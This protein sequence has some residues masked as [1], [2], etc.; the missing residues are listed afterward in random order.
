MEGIPAAYKYQQVK[1]YPFGSN[2]GSPLLLTADPWSYLYAWLGQHSPSKG[3]GKKRFERALYYAQQ[4]QGFYEASDATPLPTKATIVYYGMLNLVKAF[5]SIRGVELESMYEH[6]GLSLPH[7]RTKE[8]RVMPKTNSSLNIFH[9][10][11]N[12]LGTPVTGSK[13]ISL[14]SI[15][16][17]LP[18]IHEIT[19]S[20]NQLDTGKRKFLPI[21]IKFYVN[22]GKDKLYTEV[23]FEKKNEIRL[24]IS[25]FYKGERENYFR[26][27]SKDNSNY[28]YRSKKRKSVNETNFYRIYKNICT[29]YE[30]FNLV[31]LLGV[32][33]YK[34]YCDLKP[35]LYHHLCYSLM[36]MFYFGTVVRY[37]PTETSE[38][39]NG[40]MRPLLTEAI[41]LSPNQFLYQVVSYMTNN[42]C[43][44]PHAKI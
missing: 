10:F 7:G 1:Y 14:K 37:R 3:K 29:E 19:Y 30:K 41:A 25:K 23:Y 32:R 9:E 22:E 18:E 40:V 35:G 38:V 33:G 8:L 27:V 13:N 43:V 6:H 4:A 31:T 42:V 2:P 24:D 36:L 26:H 15:C 12:Q 44:V 34:Y 20:L 39:L 21:E 11:A 17:N 5:I 28:I 16:S